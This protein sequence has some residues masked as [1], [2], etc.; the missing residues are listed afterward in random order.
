M[1]QMMSQLAFAIAEQCQVD[2]PKQAA[3]LIAFNL[4]HCPVA[5]INERL[6]LQQ[7]C[8]SRAYVAN[9]PDHS[10]IFNHLQNQARQ[11]FHAL[12]ERNS[13]PREPTKPQII[14][15]PAPALATETE[16]LNF[17][18]ETFPRDRTLALAALLELSSGSEAD[19]AVLQLA[20]RHDAVDFAE[21]Y[22]RNRQNTVSAELEAWLKAQSEQSE[23]VSRAMSLLPSENWATMTPER[24]TALLPTL[25]RTHWSN[26][27]PV[28]D[29]ASVY[30]S[31]NDINAALVVSCALCEK[32]RLVIV[33]TAVE[34]DGRA[35]C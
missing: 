1:A 35:H 23:H 16:L 4:Q 18:V 22:T 34:L 33:C 21:S 13:A 19:E 5:L 17:A 26:L 6:A 8:S 29:L 20:K 2:A 24:F 11:A 28:L 12:N 7:H 27:Q 10:S 15:G 30:I 14:L 31:Q 25:L 9:E 32:K 3:E